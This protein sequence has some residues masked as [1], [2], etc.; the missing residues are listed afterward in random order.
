MISDMNKKMPQPGNKIPLDSNERFL[1]LVWERTLQPA[2][3]F[4]IRL[5]VGMAMLNPKTG[6]PGKPQT[7]WN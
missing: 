1:G 7:R 5:A 2:E 6:I 4:T 3:S